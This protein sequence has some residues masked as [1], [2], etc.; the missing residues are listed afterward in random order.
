M[1]IGTHAIC[2]MFLGNKDYRD[3]TWAQA[4]S[5]MAIFDELLYLSLDLLGFL[6]VDAV[7]S[8]VRKRCSQDEV[9]A[10]SDATKGR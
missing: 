10:V 8:L 9:N 3:G 2:A 1:T 5:Y 6:G 4:F 7:G